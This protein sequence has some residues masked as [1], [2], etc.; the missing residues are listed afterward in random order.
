MHY[1]DIKVEDMNLEELYI[2]LQSP[3][4]RIVLPKQL[5]ISEKSC[6]NSLMLRYNSQATKVMTP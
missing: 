5:Y 4:T 6:C 3:F 2:T 1:I